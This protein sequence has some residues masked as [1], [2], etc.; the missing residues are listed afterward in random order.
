MKLSAPPPLPH[1]VRYERELREAAPEN[2]W[3]AFTQTARA[4]TSCTC[5]RLDTGYVD[6][7]EAYRAAQEHVKKEF[8]G[9]DWGPE[10][11]K[12]HSA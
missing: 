12:E 11:G 5:G 9:V 6:A 2:D 4:R 8:P 1:S 3:C 10:I 7:D